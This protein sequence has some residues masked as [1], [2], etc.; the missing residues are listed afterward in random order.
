ME[1]YYR[2][3]ILTEC[4]AKVLS[5]AERDGRYAIELDRSIIFPEGGG[6]LSDSGQIDDAIIFEA[7]TEKGHVIH[8][9][10]KPFDEG[11][12][13]TLRLNTAARLDQHCPAYGRTYN[14]RACIEAVQCAQ[15]WLSY[16]EGVLYG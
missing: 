4:T 14:L 16:G 9:C 3:P 12:N 1:L 11:S 7:K 10:S 5:C 8:F 13:V 15:R 6:Q 2:H